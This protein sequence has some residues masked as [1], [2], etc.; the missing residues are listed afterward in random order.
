MSNSS[1]NYPD[2][3]NIDHNNLRKVNTIR[4]ADKKEKLKFVKDVITQQGVPSHFRPLPQCHTDKIF[5][6]IND[7]GKKQREWLYIDENTFYCV[8][9]LCFSER[10]GNRLVDGIEYIKGCRITEILNRHELGLSHTCARNIFAEHNGIAFN[11]D[12]AD[13]L[14]AIVKIIIYI[15]THGMYI[16][17][18]EK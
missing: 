10:K 17:K 6:T 18:H 4:N 3:S 5:Y 12:K 2:S 7:E 16:Q 13:A 8:Y 11:I 1:F 9:C 14:K 15:A